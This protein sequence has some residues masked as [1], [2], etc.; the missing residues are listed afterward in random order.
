MLSGAFKSVIFPQTPS[1]LT[2]EKQVQTYPRAAAIKLIPMLTSYYQSVL[3][4]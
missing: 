3:G 4:I 2:G 1:G